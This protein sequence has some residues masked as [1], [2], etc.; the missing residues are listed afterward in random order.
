M[1]SQKQYFRFAEYMVG[2]SLKD[3][4][5]IASKLADVVPTARH[6]RLIT[7]RLYNPGIAS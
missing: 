7:S 2:V 5:I 1:V 3:L 4:R 6:L